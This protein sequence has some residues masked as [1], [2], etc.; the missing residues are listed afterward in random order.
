MRFE[1]TVRNNDPKN[2]PA[3]EEGACPCDEEVVAVWSP[4]FWILSW[5]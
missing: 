1:I 5:V 4:I 2:D 3:D